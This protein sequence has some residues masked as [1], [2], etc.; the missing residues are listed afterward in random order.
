[1]NGAEAREVFAKA[2]VARLA[3]LTPDGAPHIV[4]ICFALDGDVIY[5]AIDDKPKSTTHPQRLRN[6]NS[7]A[8]VAVLA[9][10]YDER[11]EELWWVR[12]DGR[13]RVVSAGEQAVALLAQRYE[14]Y[15]A[16]PPRGAMIV[17]DVER[18]SGW[19]HPPAT[20]RAP[21]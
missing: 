7:D 10:H 9:D 2:R 16:R 1:M 4:P 19:R 11:W 12:A 21:S 13:A 15:R 5:S 17:I 20:E 8:R 6:I 14:Q 18:W 3:T